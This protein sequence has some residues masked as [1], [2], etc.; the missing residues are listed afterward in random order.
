VKAG[1]GLILAGVLGLPFP[2]PARET[3]SS[4]DDPVYAQIRAR[5]EDRETL[6][7]R[8]EGWEEFLHVYPG[9]PCADEA[10]K[11]LDRLRESEAHRQ[12]LERGEKWKQT[13]RGGIIEPGREV[14]PSPVGLADPV[15]R[16]RLRLTHDLI[17][18][19]DRLSTRA[20]VEGPLW[21]QILSCE[22]APVYNLGLSLQIPAMVG[23]LE[24]EGFSMLVGNIVLGVRGIWG[25]TL[26]GDDFPLVLSGGVSWGSG[27]SEWSGSDQGTL[28]DFAAYAAPNRFH[29]YRYRQTDYAVHAEGQLGVGDHF[30]ALALSYHVLAQGSPPAFLAYPRVDPVFQMFRVDLGW[31]WVVLDWLVTSVELNA[32]VGFPE[33]SKTS[34][35][36]LSPGVRLSLDRFNLAFAVQVPFLE[37]TDFSRLM[38]SIEVGMRLW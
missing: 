13:A 31:Q 36:Y 32:G 9:N 7:G 3:N 21:L 25:R 1:I 28:L 14:F 20:G 30:F 37:V 12:E 16:N 19:A 26:S 33:E 6:R 34:H 10:R 22:F 27:S 5:I 18:L 17:W 15:P 38:V 2:A 11:E 24:D 4:C 35:L 23:G 29:L 8:V